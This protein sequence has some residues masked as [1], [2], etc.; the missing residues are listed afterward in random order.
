MPSQKEVSQT[1]ENA[2]FI[3]NMSKACW[4]EKLH[5]HD[6]NHVACDKS[7]LSQMGTISG[8]MG[9]L[10]QKRHEVVSWLVI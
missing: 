1:P 4:G 5:V 2:S 7:S 3:A 9:T 8:D 10:T 6:I